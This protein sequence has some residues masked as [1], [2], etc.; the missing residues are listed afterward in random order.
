MKFSTREDISAPIDSVW[1]TVTDFRSFERRAL[2][3][4]IEVTRK[5]DDQAGLGAGWTLRFSFRG[6]QRTLETEVTGCEPP[7]NMEFSGHVGGLD[8]VFT[9]EL[10]AL[11]QSVTR[12]MISLEVKPATLPA[13]IMI[14]T[15]KLAKGKLDKRFRTQV[16]KYIKQIASA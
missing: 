1:E 2:R 14:Q 9:V 6:S 12:V 3:N 13:R 4:G 5:A 7:N 8:T 15:A 16:G 10:V 11:S